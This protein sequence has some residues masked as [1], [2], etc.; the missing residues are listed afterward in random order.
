MRSVAADQNGRRRYERSAAPLRFMYVSGLISRTLVLP[1][2]PE[3]TRASPSFRQP[4]K[5]QT[6]ARWS[7]THQPTLWRVRSYSFPGLP[8]PTMTFMGSSSRAA[9]D[10]LRPRPKRKRN[11]NELLGLGVFLS[12]RLTDQLRFSDRRRNLTLGARRGLDDRL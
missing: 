6:S 8:S 7:T 10:V 9:V 12:L 5:C 4:S 11:T 2:A 3:A 1:T